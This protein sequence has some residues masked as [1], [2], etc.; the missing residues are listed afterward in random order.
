M[1]TIIF[2]IRHGDT[3]N[4]QNIWYGRLP[5]YHLSTIGKSQ[6]KQLAKSLKSYPIK[7]IYASPLERTTETAQ[8][9]ALKFPHL[10]VQKD[11]RLLEL[12]TPTKGKTQVEMNKL[13]WNFFRPEFIH[14]GGESM[15]QLWA[16]INNFLQEKI[17]QHRGEYIAIV[18]H[19]DPIMITKVKFLGQ[20]LCLRNL[21]NR[22]NYVK[23]GHGFM[24]EFSE[25]GKFI[26][27]SDI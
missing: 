14:K 7:A 17:R 9:I 11:L 22:S 2:I 18:T 6:I 16:R 5:G 4:P 10:E 27:L 25:T 15:R 12:K 19:A 3:R 20:R 23:P 24:L 1:T 8:I 13:N 26:K 21:H